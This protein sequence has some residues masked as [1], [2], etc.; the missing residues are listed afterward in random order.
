MGG[1]SFGGCVRGRGGRIDGDGGGGG[2]DGGGLMMARM[3]AV[4]NW[5]RLSSL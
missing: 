2:G 1:M 4:G 3:T 5:K